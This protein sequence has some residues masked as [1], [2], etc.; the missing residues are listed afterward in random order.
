MFAF[1]WI[2]GAGCR[3]MPWRSAYLRWRLETYTGIPAESITAKVFFE[4]LW[5]ERKSMLTYL[6]WVSRN[7]H[8]LD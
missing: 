8:L 1:L 6:Q 2:A 4:V 5:R 3:L 7:Q